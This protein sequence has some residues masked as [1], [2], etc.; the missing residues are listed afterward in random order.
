MRILLIDDHAL[1]RAGLAL[2][3]RELDPAVDAMQ[4][5]SIA[6]ALSLSAV[7]DLVL[8]DLGLP[9]HTGIGALEEFLLQRT[10]AAP[11]VVL[12]G[13]EEPSVVR[14]CIDAGAMGY[15][16]KASDQRVLSAALDIVVA[17][18]TYLPPAALATA[19]P[20]SPRLAALLPQL[21]K[22]Q[23]DV[24]A[25]LVQGKPNKVIARELGISDLTV[26]SHVTAL[27]RELGLSNR[28]EAVFALAS[29]GLMVKPLRAG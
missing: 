20:G 23:R 16:L 2:L 18:S 11:V 13:Q 14:A 15:V 17:G 19:E 12:S 9:G 5:G 3:L 26:K 21:T 7:P 4:A 22:R 29:A 27:L 28:T 1:F 6:Q 10:H 25:H 24:L 8:L